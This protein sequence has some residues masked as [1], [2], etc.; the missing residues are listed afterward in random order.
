MKK[1]ILL[2]LFLTISLLIPFNLWANTYT[3]IIGIDK[4]PNLHNGNLQFAVSDARLFR[5]VIQKEFYI[6]DDNIYML[7]DEEAKRENIRNTITI[8]IRDK[9]TSDDTLIIYYSGHGTR[10]ED[11]PPYDESDGLDEY[12]IPYDAQSGIDKNGEEIILS[13]SAIRDDD[14]SSWITSLPVK[15][16]IILFDSC[17]SGGA[18]KGIKGF[19]LKPLATK[20][21]DSFFQ[22]LEKA[23]TKKIVVFL[24]SSRAD[25]KSIEST[26]INHGYFTY[27]LY[28]ALKQKEKTDTNKDGSIS[29]D[30]IYKAVKKKVERVTHKKQHPTLQISSKDVDPKDIEFLPI[31]KESYIEITTIPSS[32]EIYIDKKFLGRT[33]LKQV[34]NPGYHI[35]SL[36][37][38]GYKRYEELIALSTGEKKKINVTLKKENTKKEEVDLSIILKGKDG[39]LLSGYKVALTGTPYAQVTNKSGEANFS[40]IE[41]Q[42]PIVIVFDKTDN[43]KIIY[44][45]QISLKESKNKIELVI[46]NVNIA[47]PSF[48]ISPQKETYTFSI[49][50]V[51]QLKIKIKYPKGWKVVKNNIKKGILFNSES[52]ESYL[53]QV[54]RTKRSKD[55]ST[56]TKYTLVQKKW[57]SQHRKDYKELKLDKDEKIGEKTGNILIY[58]YTYKDNIYEVMEFYFEG[59]DNAYYTALLDVP[60]GKLDSLISLFEKLIRGIE[61]ESYNTTLFSLFESPEKGFKILYPKKWKV[62]TPNEDIVFYVKNG[63]KEAIQ[64]LV[65]TL[66]KG[67]GVEDYA[68][69]TDTWLGKNLRNYKKLVDTKIEKPIKG[70]KRIYTYKKGKDARYVEEYYF[71]SKYKDKKM[72]YTLI[73]ERSKSL[74]KSQIEEFNKI[75]ISI[76]KNFHIGE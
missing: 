64:V 63:T 47:S 9:L 11:L 18:E 40:N 14:F 2:C 72:G 26:R 4:Y 65:H 17:Y 35:L 1:I 46:N 49:F 19:F 12:I 69:N 7:L 45:T 61:F 70:I 32:V 10:G 22:D 44:T 28:E 58:S 31:K 66:I 53:F 51:P 54:Y 23:V 73:F 59:P 15:N 56:L 55:I 34:I 39:T 36:V 27:A 42:N 29:V 67:M 16:I 62:E 6:P 5:Y 48:I 71:V 21:G 37:K 74:T 30:E 33:P 41:N 68:K 20:G 24:A 57:L 43:R 60:E 76:L 8:K 25:E 75:K 52:S 3:F 50:T 38:K 13:W